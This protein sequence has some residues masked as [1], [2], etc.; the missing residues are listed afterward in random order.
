MEA[1]ELVPLEPPLS[2]PTMPKMKPLGTTSE[3][4]LELER[5]SGE[6]Q[7]ALKAEAYLEK[8]GRYKRGEGDEWEEQQRNLPQKIDNMKGF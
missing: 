2:I 4:A 5:L 6:R 1:D 8:A 7:S 3:L